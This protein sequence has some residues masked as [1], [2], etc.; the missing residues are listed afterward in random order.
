[1]TQDFMRLDRF[2]G[3]KFVHWQEKIM[4]LL[5]TLKVFYVLD[6][7]LKAIEPAQEDDTQ[8]VI[9]ERKKHEE[10]EFI[11]RGHILNALSNCLYDLYPN[12]KTAKEIWEDL[13]KKYKAEEEDTKKF[14]ITQ[15]MKFKFYDMKLILPQIHELHIIVNKLSTLSIILP[16]QFLVR[17]IIAKLPHS[18]RGYKKKIHHK[19]D[20]ISLEQIL[21]HLKIEEESHSRDNNEEESNG[22]TSKDNVVAK[23]PNN[24]K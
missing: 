16:E 21:K 3:T 19:N 7:D 15:Y 2:D 10:D 1:M 6:K 23:L 13:E 9:K 11:C 22:E 14:L 12:T 24:G 5:T 8:E 20:E 17:A 4:F 18:W